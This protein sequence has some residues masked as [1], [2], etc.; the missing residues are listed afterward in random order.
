MQTGPTASP[1]FNQMLAVVIADDGLHFKVM[2]QD[3]ETGEVREVTELYE[4]TPMAIT[5]D[6]KEIV[7]FHVGYI[8]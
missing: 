1:K 5:H 2:S 7:G 8:K 6:G 4:I 3:A